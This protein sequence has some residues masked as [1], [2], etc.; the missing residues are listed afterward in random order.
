MLITNSGKY[1]ITT[2]SY[3]AEWLELTPDGAVA[4]APGGLTQRKLVA[5]F[6]L[7][8]ERIA[9]FSILYTEYKC[10]RLPSREVMKDVLA[11]KIFQLRRFQNVLIPS[12]SMPKT[13]D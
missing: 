5:Q 11:D 10:K 6:R 1:G 2:G 9:P 7:A 4:T 3:A 13:S 8:I 12:L